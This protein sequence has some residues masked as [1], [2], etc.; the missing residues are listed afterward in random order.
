M[1]RIDLFL[2]GYRIVEIEKSDVKLAAKL[3][4]KN[5]INVKIK[6]ST[7]IVSE[8]KYKEISHL[9]AD[10]VKFSASELKGF[11]GL[12]YKNRKKY[13]VFCA[14]LFTLILFA[15]TT[16]RVWD[17]R[18]EGENVSFRE[19]I[20]NEL[21]ECGFSVG[22]SFK[23]LDFSKIEVALLEKSEYVSWVNINRRGNVAY[24]TVRN[25]I[26][27]PDKEEKKGYSNIVAACDAVIEEITVT[28]GVAMVKPGESVRA[29]E[30]LISGILPAESGGGFCYAEGVVTGRITDTIEVTAANKMSSKNPEKRKICEIKVNFFDFSAKIFKSYRKTDKQYAI[31]ERK[32][33]PRLFGKKLPI[34]FNVFY[35]EFFKL[36]TVGLSESEMAENAL[37]EMRQRLEA[38]LENATL[39]KLRSEG[40]F[41]DSGYVLKTY[42]VLTESIGRDLPFKVEE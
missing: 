41:S 25:K 3:F 24:V 14:L 40:G 37:L 29:G 13:G 20:E 1:M 2:F 39:V 6:N 36:E 15:L 32:V 30:L 21:R 7:L 35:R 38:R 42:F 22:Q 26:S 23:K 17:V 18:I 12:V 33:C 4:L 10:R 8:L 34:S 5:K 31:I 27:Y 16:G 9:L 11:P 28:K 19:E